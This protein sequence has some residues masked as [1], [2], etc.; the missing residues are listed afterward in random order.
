MLHVRIVVPPALVD[1]VLQYLLELDTVINVVHLRG[2]A[3]KPKGDLVTCDVPREEGSVVLQTLSDLGCDKDG[4]VTVDTIGVS[5]S[6]AAQEAERR[7]V[8]A[9]AEAVVWEEVE[10]HTTE[11]ADL[12]F[13][14]VLFMVLAAIIAAVGIVTD[15]VVLIVGAMVVSPEFGPLAGL[16]VAL[17]Q[18]RP[19][20][21]ARS[22]FA[23]AAGFA[24]AIG[25]AL[26]F[27]LLLARS[28][29]AAASFGAAHP[30]TM[31]I[32]RPDAYSVVIAAT[33]GIAG[34][35]SLTTAKPGALIGVFISIT[36]LPAAANL[37][38]AGAM[39]TGTE[40]RGAALQLAINLATLVVVGTATLALQRLA[41]VRRWK[42]ALHRARPAHAPRPRRPRQG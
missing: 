28:G 23:L 5:L 16:C 14:Y 10:A 21:A 30:Q 38:V 6:V 7:A 25:A 36:T 34:M 19:A 40:A 12:S 9:G 27:T 41:F 24:A 37:G 8:G 29:V 2:V 31:F 15:S 11:S 13:S 33:A 20:L 3:A 39:G 26:L 42:V 22:A 1:R 18:R 32:S 17:M 35:V 4:T